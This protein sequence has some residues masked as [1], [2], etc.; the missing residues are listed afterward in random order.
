[1][2]PQLMDMTVLVDQ[3]ELIY[4]SSVRTQGL[5]WK[6]Y[7]KR[8]MIGTD[9]ERES[10][11]FVLSVRLDDDDNVNNKTRKGTREKNR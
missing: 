10:G 2:D 11:E 4:I 1:M 8:R 6:T 9:G 5:V 3:Q 7:Q